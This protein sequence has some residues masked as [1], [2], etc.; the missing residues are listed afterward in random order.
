MHLEWTAPG[1]QNVRAWSA[2]S[3]PWPET[4]TEC[5]QGMEQELR[6]PL[7]CQHVSM[8]LCRQL[9]TFHMAL[10]LFA[11]SYHQKK[12]NSRGLLVSE[13]P[14]TLLW[15]RLCTSSCWFRPLHLSGTHLHHLGPTLAPVG[16]PGFNP[17]PDSCT[18]PAAAPQLCSAG[19][20]LA[21]GAWPTPGSPMSPITSP[22]C[23]TPLAPW[24]AGG[25]GGNQKPVSLI[26]QCTLTLQTK[27]I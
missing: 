25:G 1:G 7:G 13:F 10:V 4:S 16:V 15:G 24:K 22:S 26:T 8:G 9:K 2:R 11:W 5:G 12:N 23:S 20:G 27:H 17:I 6:T 14:H 18:G 21:A 19:R 3:Q